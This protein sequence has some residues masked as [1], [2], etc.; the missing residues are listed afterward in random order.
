MEQ[1]GGSKSGMEYVNAVYCHPAHLT[2]MQCECESESESEVTQSCPT[3]CDPVDYSPPGSSVH[4][5]LQTRIL[6][7]VAISFSSGSSQLRDQAQVSRIAGRRFNFCATREAC[8]CRVYVYAEYIPVYAEYIMLNARLDEA[9]AGIKI[10]GRNINNLR[11][12]DDT[13]LTAESKEVK[14][15]LMKIKG[16]SEK[17]GLKLSIQKTKIMASSPVTSWQIGGETMETVRD[18]ILGGSKITADGD[19]RQEIKR[20]LLLGRKAMTNLDSILKSRD[21]ILPTNVHIVKAIVYQ[22]VMYGCENLTIKKAER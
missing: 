17:V 19:C 21:I 22:L 18:F 7:W 1:Q 13:T 3:L 10:A 12:A 8:I 20:P 16:E 14:S 5:I 9:Q 11:Y 4:G 15:L 2:Y 6:E